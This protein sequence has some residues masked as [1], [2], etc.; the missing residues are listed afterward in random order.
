MEGEKKDFFLLNSIEISTRGEDI[1]GSAVKQTEMVR[2][3]TRY[4]GY[5]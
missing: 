4:T 2:C 3:G 5:T 1:M